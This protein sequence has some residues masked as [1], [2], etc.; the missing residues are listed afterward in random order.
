M[1][2]NCQGDVMSFIHSRE[3]F[4]AKLLIYTVWNEK[5]SLEQGIL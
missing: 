1:N 3:K 2:E 5:S 4:L